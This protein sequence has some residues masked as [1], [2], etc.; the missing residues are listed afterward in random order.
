[1]T[2]TPQ[3]VADTCRRALGTVRALTYCRQ[4]AAERGP[5]WQLYARAGGII[6]AEE[7]AKPADKA[8]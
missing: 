2:S 6:I 4:I 5:L 3:Q 1:M 7:R 8:A